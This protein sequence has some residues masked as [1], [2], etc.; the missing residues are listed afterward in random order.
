MNLTKRDDVVELAPKHTVGVELGVAEGVF[1]ERV[2]K[3]QH[4]SHLYSVDMYADDRGHDIEQYK[5][6]FNR[7]RPY[8]KSSTILKM[9]FD[10]AVDLFEDNSLGF[11]YIDGYAHT[12]QED[13]VTL[14]Q[15]YPKLMSGGVFSGDDYHLHHPATIK[16]VDRFVKK[17]NLEL[18]VIDCHEPYSVWSEYP[19]WY[20][21]KP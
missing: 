8:Q 4:L 9:R 12:G 7:F 15:W 11:I 5:R 16:T 14:E 13:G 19:T 2:L 3:K 17:Y 18:H 6:A 1:S 20:I 10:Q 21:I